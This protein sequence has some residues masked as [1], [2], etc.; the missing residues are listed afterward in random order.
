MN[1]T[2]LLSISALAFAMFS[3]SGFSAGDES[4]I[5]KLSNFK[6]TGGGKGDS[7]S[8]YGTATKTAGQ[9]PARSV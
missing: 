9:N 5:D 1:K 7:N 6:S 4:N 8:N 2:K 3:S